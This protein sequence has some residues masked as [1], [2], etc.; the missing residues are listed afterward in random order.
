MMLGHRSH[1]TAC[2]PTMNTKRDAQRPYEIAPDPQKQSYRVTKTLAIYPP[3]Q[4]LLI[5]EQV[6]IGVAVL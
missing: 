2:V 4:A 1:K 3:L 6:I 5:T